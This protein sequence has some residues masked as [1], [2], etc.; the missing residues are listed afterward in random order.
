MSRI[1]RYCVCQNFL[2]AETGFQYDKD[3]EV[4]DYLSFMIL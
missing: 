3:K 1:F 2:D 4:C